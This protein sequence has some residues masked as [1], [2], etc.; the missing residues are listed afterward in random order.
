MSDIFAALNNGL[1]SYYYILNGLV[2]TMFCI[3]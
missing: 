3:K 1:I 2:G